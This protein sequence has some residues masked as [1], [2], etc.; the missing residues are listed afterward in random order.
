MQ[1]LLRMVAPGSE[2]TGGGGIGL[3][4]GGKRQRTERGESA[5]SKAGASQEGAAIKTAALSG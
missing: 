1:T 3:A 2:R 5:G 4:D